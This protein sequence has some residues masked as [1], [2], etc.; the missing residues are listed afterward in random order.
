MKTSTSPMSSP[1]IKEEV[2]F[3]KAT[4]ARLKREIH[5]TDRNSRTRY[6][7]EFHENFCDYDSVASRDD[8]TIAATSPILFT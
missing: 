8:I 3:Q 7:R 2:A 4:V 1:Q 6:I 5:G